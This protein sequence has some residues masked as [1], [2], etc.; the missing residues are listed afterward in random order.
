MRRVRVVS[1]PVSKRGTS[2]T[3]P[4]G[5]PWARREAMASMATSK[6]A[7]RRVMGKWAAA[8]ARVTAFTKRTAEQERM[9][10][11]ALEVGLQMISMSAWALRSRDSMS[12]W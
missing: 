3:V 6:W 12:P 7:A 5:A 10:P 2:V 1:T 9:M 11:V 8:V 4:G